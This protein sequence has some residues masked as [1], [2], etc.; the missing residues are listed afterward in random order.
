[1]D[2]QALTILIADD[3]DADRL[4]LQT[5]IKSQGHEV[6][7][8]VDGIDAVEKFTQSRPQLVLMDALMP[9][10]N[11]FEA[12][13]EIKRIAGVDM[14]PIIF[15]TSLTDADSLV[16]CLNSGGDDF[17]SK[18]YNPII[19]K[20]KI[21]AFNR[22][23]INHQHLQKAL[24]D[25]EQSQAKLVQREKM[26]S[27]GELV[28]GIAHEVN[29]P[30]GIGVTA[31]THLQGMLKEL[32]ATY[33][34][35]EL[36]AEDLEKFMQRADESALI[37][38]VN[39]DRSAKLIKSF[40]QVAVDQSCDSLRKITLQDHMQD[41]LMSMRPQL[42]KLNHQITINC[43][44]SLQCLCDAGALTQVMTNLIMN[45]IIHGF[46]ETAEGIITIDI[47]EKDNTIFIIYH[48]NG[49]GMAAELLKKIFEPFFTTRRGDG[50]SGLGTHIIY[51]QVSQ[52][53]HGHITV[54]S[55]PGKGMTFNIDFPTDGSTAE[56]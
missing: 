14:I 40:K 4:I 23:R 1:M 47:S 7:T 19:L 36:D 45:S 18:P 32:K 12:V 28:A 43:D 42:K 13:P 51:N 33:D 44:D 22:M 21:N 48:D 52:A 55:E 9:R 15:L 29:T 3:S 8:A 39:L 49:A 20:A 16:Q 50:G 6:I 27:L 10:M 17:L 54:T 31:I 25:L 53:L 24:T 2:E 34:K 56:A 35:G 37:T 46:N 30:I 41:I 26:A 38:Q 11:G 5:I